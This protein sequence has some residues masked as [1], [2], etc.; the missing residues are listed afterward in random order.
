MLNQLQMLYL[1]FHQLIPVKQLLLLLPHIYCRKLEYT[2]NCYVTGVNDGV[3]IDGDQDSLIT[4]SINQSGSDDGFDA[5]ADKTV[6]AT[7]TDDDV[8]GFTVT[9]TDGST[10][11]AESG[12]TDTF[13]VVLDAQ[14][15][16][17]VVFNISPVDSTESSVTSTTFTNGNWDTP[18]IVTVT[19]VNDFLIDGTITAAIT[20]SIDDANSN[21]DFALTDQSVNVSTLDDDVAG[22]TVTE[23]DGSTSVNESGI[24][25][26]TIVLT[27]QPVSDVVLT[28]V[29]SDNTESSATSTV[30]FTTNNWNTAQS[31]EVVAVDEFI[32]DGN[33]NSTLTIAIDDANSD[34]D[35]DALDDQTVTV[36]TIDDDVA[37]FE[38]YR[39]WWRHCC[40]E[41]ETSD[42]FSVALTAQPSSNVE[43]NISQPNNPSSSGLERVTIF[44]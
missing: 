9:E 17:D 39:N 11:V 21:A 4:I 27:A 10:Q 7:T 44:K 28:I 35:F 20:V 23:T 31:V 40:S 14:P 33:Q 18:Q 8:P 15:T 12:T 2:T 42:T 34:D 5:L 25:D 1:I 32:I 41:S 36:Q 16:S 29:S 19:G 26:T 6:T 22:F 38:S 24:N 37:G 43:L 30:T 13:T 3:L